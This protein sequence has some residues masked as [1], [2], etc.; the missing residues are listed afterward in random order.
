MTWLPGNETNM[1]LI[2]FAVFFGRVSNTNSWPWKTPTKYDVSEGRMHPF[3]RSCTDI[4][5]LQAKCNQKH[6][7]HCTCRIS[8]SN[9]ISGL[10]NTYRIRVPRT[11]ILVTVF[12]EKNPDNI[13]WPRVLCSQT[14]YRRRYNL[15]A[16]PSI[17]TTM[18]RELMQIVMFQNE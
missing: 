14:E 17:P 6:A 16:N 11:P 1:F 10:W 5:C 7:A 18:K 3:P 4:P 8:R 9:F 12:V 13:N 15:S 2:F